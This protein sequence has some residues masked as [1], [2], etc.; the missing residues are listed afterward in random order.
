M[1][2]IDYTPPVAFGDLGMSWENPDARQAKYIDA[3]RIALLERGKVNGLR[4]L[5]YNPQ[6]IPTPFRKLSYGIMSEIH[7]QTMATIPYFVD[8]TVNSGDFSG[9]DAIPMLTL[10]RCLEILGDD[11]L[12]LPQPI[13]YGSENNL[14]L[15]QQYRIINLLRWARRTFLFSS[16]STDLRAIG[17]Y[18]NPPEGRTFSDE[19]TRF[20]ATEWGYNDGELFTTTIA[21]FA[22]HREQYVEDQYISQS[23]NIS[24]RRGLYDFS[25]VTYTC[26][27]DLYVVFQPYVRDYYNTDYPFA[28]VNKYY[29]LYNQF[30][31][32]GDNDQIE[33]G[34][35]GD[36]TVVDPMSLGEDINACGWLVY[37]TQYDVKPNTLVA[38]LDVA[39]G[40][41]FG[42]WA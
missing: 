10:R 23:F 5:I 24:R 41:K 31:V 38:K 18:L 2:L 32:N 20:N 17:S 19:V 11:R 27:A 28:E 26:V 1:A 14:W 33:I 30:E 13:G 42:D 37:N 7:A 40:F 35:F 15:R 16:T 12:Y 6:Y 3:I 8:F 25:D 39:N 22:Y 4:P 21:H 29:R 34:N 36:A 9:L